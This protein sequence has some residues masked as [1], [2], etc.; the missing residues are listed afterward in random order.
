MNDN[1]WIVGVCDWFWRYAL[2]AVSL[3]VFRSWSVVCGCTCSSCHI[4]AVDIYIC[5]IRHC[6]AL[7]TW[8]DWWGAISVLPVGGCTSVVT[9]VFH[10]VRVTAVGLR[11]AACLGVVGA[12]GGCT[13]GA[14]GACCSCTASEVDG[15]VIFC[16]ATLTLWCVSG[17][18]ASGWCSQMWSCAHLYSAPPMTLTM[19]EPWSAA[20]T[21][22]AGSHSVWSLLITET[23]QK[24]LILGFVQQVSLGS[25][26]SLS[27]SLPAGKSCI[28]E[29]Q[30]DPWSCVKTP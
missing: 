16:P 22:V 27:W 5:S 26:Q 28:V 18:T 1:E 10:W 24:Q 17:L 23:D 4:I 8:P 7:L 21:I 25:Q 15:V 12:T 20:R 9:G 19:Y 30:G 2:W 3:S 13:A 6:G 14:V 11:A 29:K